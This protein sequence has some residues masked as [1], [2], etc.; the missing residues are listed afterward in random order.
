MNVPVSPVVPTSTLDTKPAEPPSNSEDMNIDSQND[1]HPPEDD[2][3]VTVEKRLPRRDENAPLPTWSNDSDWTHRLDQLSSGKMTLKKSSK[4]VDI[5]AA[6]LAAGLVMPPI[7]ATFK[8]KVH[9]TNYLDEAYSIAKANVD[10]DADLAGDAEPEAD[11]SEDANGADVT[12]SALY[13]QLKKPKRKSS[14]GSESS[15]LS[16]SMKSDPPRPAT[17]VGLAPSTS[18]SRKSSMKRSLSADCQ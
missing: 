16:S 6:I 15:S 18:T 5:L 10:V 12:L 9:Y 13:P 4:V 11:L 8:H 2:L 7:T 1:N 14:T 3:T 17:P